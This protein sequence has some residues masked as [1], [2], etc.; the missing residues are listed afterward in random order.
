MKQVLKNIEERVIWQQ[1]V[2]KILDY[3]AR[4]IFMFLFWTGFIALALYVYR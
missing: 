4:F 3:I 1:K 2:F